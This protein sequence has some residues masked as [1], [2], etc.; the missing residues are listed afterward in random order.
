MIIVK[1]IG[2]LGNQLFQYALG[3]HLAIKNDVELKLDISSFQTYNL[4]NF[5]LSKFNIESKFATNSEL[6]FR[7]RK[8]QVNKIKAF[9]GDLVLSRI[10]IIK[11]KSFRYD[12]KILN[13]RRDV[14]I[15]GYWQSEMYFKPIKET[16]KKEIKLIEKLNHKQ[17]QLLHLIENTNSIS[18]HVRRG[19]YVQNPA[20]TSIYSNCSMEYYKK[21]IEKIEKLVEK[22]FFFIF[23]DD[24]EWVKNNLRI[25]HENMLVYGNEAVVDLTLMASCK[26]NIIANSTFSWW[27]AYLG[28]YS[29]KQVISPE[30]WFTNSSK[31][32]I[33]DLLPEDWI[34]LK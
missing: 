29:Q 1:I 28:D 19:D 9:L 25:E 34:K 24:V 30:S 14:Y 12:P 23:S 17:Q 11:E 22:P 18:V 3:R 26:H 32:N 13:Y 5:E 10:S 27:G 20:N 15:E 31:I 6:P 33:T 21:A 16:L 2:G 8:P 4:R 7:R